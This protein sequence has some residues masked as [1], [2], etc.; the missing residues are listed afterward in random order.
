MGPAVKWGEG[1][2]W[3]S[4]VSF[5]RR[6]VEEDIFFFCLILSMKVVVV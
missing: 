1:F 6:R 4:V 5:R 3:R 2:F